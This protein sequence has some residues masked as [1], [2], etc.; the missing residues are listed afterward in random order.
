MRHSNRSG[1]GKK[2]LAAFLVAAMITGNTL[3]VL[4]EDVRGNTVE[5]VEEKTEETSGENTS[6]ENTDKEN[7]DKEN[8]G[9]ASEEE[10]HT[11]ESEEGST[12]SKEGETEAVSETE[13]TDET[14]TESGLEQDTET[15]DPETEVET[16]TETGTGSVSGNSVSGN[17]I[18]EEA[19]FAL[20]YTYDEKAVSVEGPVRVEKEETFSFRVTVKEGYTL[21]EV[22]CGGEVL[23]AEEPE[24]EE[25]YIFPYTCDMVTEDTEIVI[26]TEKQ[27]GEEQIFEK[28]DVAVGNGRATITIKAAADDENLKGAE[29]V[30]DK[31]AADTGLLEEYAQKNGMTYLSHMDFGLHFEK[32]GEDG[33]AEVVQPSKQVKVIITF[34]EAPAFDGGVQKAEL[35][36]VSAGD[37]KQEK[38]E[39]AADLYEMPK[40][41]YRSARSAETNAV[42]KEISFETDSFSPFPIVLL[43]SGNIYT[44][45]SWANKGTY[46][47]TS[48]NSK[49][50]AN[51][52]DITE[53]TT[54]GILVDVSHVSDEGYIKYTIPDGFNKKEI[55]INA[56]NDLNTLLNGTYM[57]GCKVN[58]KI[59]LVNNSGTDY[60]YVNNSFYIASESLAAQYEETDEKYSY[61]W[62]YATS[63]PDIVIG[64][65][66]GAIGFDGSPLLVLSNTAWSPNRTSN[67]ALLFLLSEYAEE[68]DLE[69]F[70]DKGA[71]LKDLPYSV[72]NSR[73]LTDGYLDGVLKR[74]G[75]EGI[76]E[77]N[78][79]YLDYYNRHY[80]TN[81]ASLEELPLEALVSG[82]NKA[83]IFGGNRFKMRETNPEVAEC[84]YNFFYNYC[85][86]LLP[87]GVSQAE[88]RNYSI[89]NWMR[90]ETG[91][92]ETVRASFAGFNNGTEVELLGLNMMIDGPYTANV[93][94][95][96]NF[97]WSLGLKLTS[98]EQ[99]T[100]PTPPTPPTP[101]EPTPGNPTPTPDTP[102]PVATTAVL[103]ISAAPDVAVLGEAF[104][105]QSGVL[106]ESKGPGTGDSSPVIAWS[107]AALGAAVCLAGFAVKK[108]KKKQ[109]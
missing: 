21:L 51:P 38:V 31:E 95:D 17:D 89:G 61:T 11:R 53:S 58:F 88:S 48:G 12:E 45:L 25:P 22:T 62:N 70:N 15:E 109:K 104:P 90:G 79:Y 75:Y 54:D 76:K 5:T 74:A 80:G 10:S 69:K 68:R 6:G 8:A 99:T 50:K 81:A 92:E 2:V 108:K 40:A 41:E 66:D 47:Y 94:M 20:T 46:S 60:S 44:P 30:A 1:R 64:W 23:S 91:Y 7:T 67:K 36:H 63:K 105:P 49:W 34:T 39:K 32:K 83:G 27:A 73:Y 29:L 43:S 18:T 71:P 100:P 28:K 77:L 96:M 87:D 4:A 97:G 82:S 78:H 102:A 103:G 14:Q 72:A 85:L 24:A 42:Q 52:V 55:N 107:L 35:L 16:E 93:Y 19:G 86:S 84:G 9:E 57:P 56:I 98:N 106:G 26:R 37:G 33:T 101:E 13:S 65:V 59:K 3:T